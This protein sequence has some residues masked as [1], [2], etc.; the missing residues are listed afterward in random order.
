VPWE[1]TATSFAPTAIAAPLLV[2]CLLA[3]LGRVLPRLLVDA[4][5]TAVTAGV[6]AL[7]VALLLSTRHGRVVTWVGGWTPSHEH[8]VGIALVA[9]RL[10][11]GLALLAAV[12]VLAAL[13]Y[14]WRYLEDVGAHYQVLVLVFLAGTTGFALSGDIFDMFVFFELMGA[15][16]YALTGFFVED[17]TAVQGALNFGV[18]N[19]LGAYLTLMGIGL[20]YARYGALGLPQLSRA[21]AG[22]RPDVLLL[23]AFTLICTG[24]L[25]KAAVVPVHFWTADAEAVAPTP[26]CLL[27]SGVMVELGLY[28]VARIYW[29]TFADVLPPSDV[30]RALLVLG[31]LTAVVGAPMCFLQRHLKR[32]LAYST[33]A[34]VGLFLCALAT[35]DGAGTTGAALYV[36]G[37]A[38]VKGALF[39][40]AGT[41]LNRYGSVDE[42]ALH[43]RGRDARLAP[44]L[45][46]LG[47]L[48]LACLP[49]FG[50]GLGKAVGE[51]A[52]STAG[53]P[54][55][56]VLFVAVSAI[57]GAAV[58]RAGARIYFGLGPIPRHEDSGAR[59]E[60]EPERETEDLPRIRITMLLPIVVLLAGSLAVGVV[61][62][63]GRAVSVAATEFLD[64]SGY[65]DQALAGTPATPPE[66]LAEAAWT[67]SG[68]LLGLLSAALAVGLAALAVGA[69]R[70]P[71]L[72]RAAAR[73]LTVALSG[74][75]RLHSGHVGDYVAWL[76]LGVAAFAALLG[77]PLIGG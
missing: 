45:F 16:A 56:P 60:D 72:L 48:A 17:R 3:A 51:E 24:L 43:G 59:T 68:V 35:L 58:L 55:G 71:S 73:P 30:R 62:A 69:P 74:L 34:H 21:M 18:I 15:V 7:D 47:G 49:P 76:F 27:F 42:I 8:S 1:G 37:H 23:A 14:S 39:L 28:G 38:G 50:T 20:L 36:L 5:A 46:V 19:S 33:I 64:G 75:R 77:V 63:V 13:V 53:Y 26:V 6:V 2:A 12:L 25:V 10:S 31:V 61:P 29:T 4:A 11:A 54:W 52:L 41:L 66:A 65:V 40:L 67:T 22:A 32:L 44:W 70:L 9:D 57:T